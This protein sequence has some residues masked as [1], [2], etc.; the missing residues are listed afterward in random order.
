MVLG[1]C[2]SAYSSPLPFSSVQ[3]QGEMPVTEIFRVEQN[4][5]ALNFNL[6]ESRNSTIQVGSYTL[7]SNN[8]VSQFKL[9]VRPGQRGDEQQFSFVLDQAE[10]ILPGQRSVIPFSVRVVSDTSRGMSVSGNASMQKD[11]G[12]RGVYGNNE[13]ILYESGQILAEI[14]DFDPNQFATGWYSA[15]IELSIEVL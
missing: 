12:V 7:V 6:A 13:T 5:Q 9:A 8:A 2:A 11:L 3:V 15:A 4:Q 14:P 10:T 1:L